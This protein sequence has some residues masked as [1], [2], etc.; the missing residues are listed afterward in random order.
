MDEGC[1]SFNPFNMFDQNPKILCETQKDWES[2]ELL[3]LELIQARLTKDSEVYEKFNLLL[4]QRKKGVSVEQTKINEVE[5]LRRIN[6]Y[7]QG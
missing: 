4:E 2:L 6:D 7:M 5:T 3:P 1:Y